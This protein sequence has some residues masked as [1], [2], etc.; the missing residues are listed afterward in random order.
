M[1]NPLK[2]LSQDVVNVIKSFELDKKLEKLSTQETL[3]DNADAK[4]FLNYL[5]NQYKAIEPCAG[6]DASAA[7]N[8]QTA[9][10]LIKDLCLAIFTKPQDII[11]R[12]KQVGFPSDEIEKIAHSMKQPGV[13][14]ADDLI[15]SIA[16][17]A[18]SA[19]CAA[20][21]TG[22][23]NTHSRGWFFNTP[24][25]AMPTFFRPTIN[26]PTHNLFG[27]VHSRPY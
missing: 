5:I 22:A 26:V 9:K 23:A 3:L 15:T 17:I 12:L 11:S 27:N 2:T 14:L 19:L 13:I 20:T 8:L 24:T 10:S 21:S 6:K 25:N 18:T 7:K 4:E 1:M 16:T